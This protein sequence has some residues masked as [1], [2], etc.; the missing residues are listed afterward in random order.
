MKV[1]FS[2]LFVGSLFLLNSCCTKKD[3]STPTLNYVEFTGFPTSELDSATLT[4]LENGIATSQEKVATTE[5]GGYESAYFKTAMRPGGSYQIQIVP[6]GEV[7]RIG[8]IEMEQQT[9]NRCFPVRPSSEYYQ[10]LKAYSV[11]DTRLED[12]FLRIAKP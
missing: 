12:P 5:N 6:T 10:S 9:C 2:S 1:T 3:C 7:F 4:I 11:N 8:N